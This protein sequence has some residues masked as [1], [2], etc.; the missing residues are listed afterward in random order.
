MTARSGSQPSPESI[1]Q[2]LRDAA[3]QYGDAPALS[4]LG[5]TLSFS[6][7]DDFSDRF[8]CWLQGYT[9]LRTAERLGIQ[10]PNLLAYPIVL[11]GALRAGLSVVNANPLLTLVEL[12]QQLKDSGTRALVALDGTPG[13]AAAAG[14]GIEHLMVTAPGD[15]HPPLRRFL[16]NRAW[17]RR[18]G[19]KMVPGARPLRPTLRNLGNGLPW[20]ALSDIALLQYTGGTTGLPKAVMLG[21]DNVCVNV[22]QM[23]HALES[24]SI[25]AAAR[26]FL[27]LPMYHIYAFTTAVCCLHLGHHLV[28][29]PDA[30]DLKRIVQEWRRAPCELFFGLNTLFAALCA[31]PEFCKLDFSVL[32]A[33]ISG[34][35]ALQPE[36]E[37]RWQ[38]VT[39]G[40]IHEGYGLTEASPVISLSPGDANRQGC[41]GLPLKGCEVRVVNQERQPL[42]ARERGELEVRGPQVMR[43]YWQR[44]EETAMVLDE[45]GWL[46]TGDIAEISD[47]GYIRIVDRAKDL[48]IVSG[49]NVYP[50]EVERAACTHPQVR[51]CVAVGVSDER[52]GEAVKLVVVPAGELPD[53]EELRAWCRKQLA[54]YKVPR[55]VEF[56]QE[57]PKS[58]VGKVLRRKV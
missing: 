30:R 10:L 15:F 25:P 21:H 39:G 47:E 24:F 17:H 46:R 34:G 12:K 35:M 7:L 3:K 28:L 36:T 42:P 50:A 19:Q 52:S 49:F 31:H 56:R 4:C 40:P 33:T 18:T 6:E 55:H 26:V 44:P 45:D 9:D 53:P 16:I 5:H 57:L 48:I 29:V 13:A 11:F 37:R 41:V 23:V 14:L 8:A 54:P 22:R 51:E 2:L 38:Q 58:G 43:G 20:P 27:P 32:R 1:P